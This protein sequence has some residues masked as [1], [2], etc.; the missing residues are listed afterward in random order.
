[1]ARHSA[2]SRRSLLV[3]KAIPPPAVNTAIAAQAAASGLLLLNRIPAEN[4]AATATLLAVAT[5]SDRLLIHA[6]RLG[7][8]PRRIRAYSRSARA[9]CCSLAATR[10][11]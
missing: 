9:F 6:N 3:A 4:A 8:C 7:L 2:E 11:D 1:M 10:T 5:R